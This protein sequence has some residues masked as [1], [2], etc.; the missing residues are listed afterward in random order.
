MDLLTFWDFNT[1]SHKAL[2]IELELL[3]NFFIL[4]YLLELKGYS[5]MSDARKYDGL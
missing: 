2:Y 1:I 4:K 5:S 3:L